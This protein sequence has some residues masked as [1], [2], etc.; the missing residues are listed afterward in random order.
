[1][2]AKFIMYLTF[3]DAKYD[4][5][6]FVYDLRFRAD[7][8]DSY[9]TGK[10]IDFDSHCLFWSKYYTYYRIA[11]SNERKIGFYGFVKSDFRYAV[12][13]ER[14]GEGI[15]MQMIKDAI[16]KHNLREAKVIKSNL[17]SL[18]CFEKAGFNISDKTYC[19]AEH[20][21][22]IVKLR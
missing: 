8:K 14:R 15:G 20:E 4:D 12:V 2:R 1:M 13:P 5:A 7:D 3:R 6:R 10:D 18:R 19:E 17:A 11:L 16:S 22:V 9:L 21:Y